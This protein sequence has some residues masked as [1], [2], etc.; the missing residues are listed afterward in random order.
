[1][2]DA[3]MPS[4]TPVRNPLPV[5]PD[6]GYGRAM[7][8]DPRAAL[9]AFVSALE[10]H[11]ELAEDRQGEDDPQV[12]AGYQRIADAFLTYDDALLD[13]FGEVTPLDIYSDDDDDDL[14][15]DENDDELDIDDDDEVED[16]DLELV[17]LD[18][19][20]ERR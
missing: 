9:A 19:D 2:P 20:D 8:T 15:A 10:S 12:V 6:P 18:A 7:T 4:T 16:E 14:D 3:G 17:D 5:A 1:M 11:L 13:A